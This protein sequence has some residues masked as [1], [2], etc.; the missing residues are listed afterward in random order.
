MKS[1][2][3]NLSVYLLTL[4]TSA[5]Y[6]W[7][8]DP[9][10]TSSYIT[11]GV[12]LGLLLFFLITGGLKNT[13]ASKIPVFILFWSALYV[14]LPADVNPS[15]SQGIRILEPLKYA[16]E[17]IIGNWQIMVTAIAIMLIFGLFYKANKSIIIIL[18]KY[19][20]TCVVFYGISKGIA[21]AMGQSVSWTTLAV[22]P[23]VIGVFC[24]CKELNGAIMDVEKHAL[25]RF[26]V[27]SLVYE[28]AVATVFNSIAFNRLEALTSLKP[29]LLMVLVALGCAGLTLYET[30]TADKQVDSIAQSEQEDQYEYK[31]QNSYA[32]PKSQIDQSLVAGASYKYWLFGLW[33]VLTIATKLLIPSFN[34]VVLFSGLAIAN[35]AYTYYRQKHLSLLPDVKTGNIDYK[36]WLILFLG[37]LILERLSNEKRLALIPICA[38]AIAYVICLAE[39]AKH[40][41]SPVM[42]CFAGVAVVIIKYLLTFKELNAS[43]IIVTLLLAAAWTIMCIYLN[44]VSENNAKVCENEYVLARSVAKYTPA[45]LYIAVS[46]TYL[47]S[48]A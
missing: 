46:L 18:I 2:H 13:F 40:I 12:I 42:V 34:P 7:K 44:K 21:E 38:L 30:L 26:F 16:Y 20:A 36:A 6:L 10:T 27:V 43:S 48:A 15:A 45:V 4:A 1:V 11:G 33:V 32:D 19:A 25:F 28:L 35:V 29:W 39:K 47:F 9:K 8:L 22:V 37:V 17:Q 14:L 41:S 31:E 3:I 5:V 23:L 24:C